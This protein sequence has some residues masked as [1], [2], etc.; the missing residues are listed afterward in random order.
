MVVQGLVLLTSH[1]ERVGQG[2]QRTIST[3][4]IIRKM[5]S[6]IGEGATLTVRPANELKYRKHD[7]ISSDAG[8]E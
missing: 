8:L 2:N 4:G 5:L 3:L 7:K 6:E 1:L